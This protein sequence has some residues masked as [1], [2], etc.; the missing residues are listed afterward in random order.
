MNGVQQDGDGK[1]R[2]ESP[3]LQR[4]TSRGHGPKPALIAIDLGAESCRVSLLRWV[5]G[6]PDLQLVHRFPNGPVH[7]GNSLRWDIGRI[8]EGVRRGLELCAGLA[9]EGIAALGV[10]GWAVDYVRLAADGKPLQN[11]FCYRD[12]RNV[13]ALRSVHARIS[14]R[15]LYALT[16]AQILTLNTLYQLHADTGH[17][18]QSFP[19]QNVPE[20]VL[21]YLGGRR[22][23][24]YTNAT[25]TQLLDV[26]SQQW[27][28]EIFE[29][30]R[31]DLKAAPP[32]VKPGSV[33]GQ[34]QGPLAALPALRDTRLIAPACHDT[35]SA[36]AGIPAHGD[37]WGF[38][39]SG[40]WSLV[41]GVLDVPCVTEAAREENFSNEGGVGG[42]IYFLKNVNGMWLL[43][44]CIERW[45]EQGTAWMPEKLV[46]AC[47][48]L[49][50]P[51]KL[52][53]V[54]DPTLL[55][56]GHMPSRINAQLGHLGASPIPEEPAMAP[57]VASLIFHSLAA[58]YAAV[59][60]SL[61]RVTG[62]KLKRLFVVGG[63]AKNTFLNRLTAQAT[64]LEVLTGSTE[65]TTIGN[66]AIQLAALSGDYT[67]ETGVLGSAV[68]SWAEVLS[69]RPVKLVSAQLP[70]AIIQ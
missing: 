33:V 2:E 70:S 61:A 60:E 49:P 45:Q 17:I 41:G 62:K 56:P 66:F 30:A 25:H 28:E 64:G 59:L 29:A 11:P 18:E 7:E 15:R 5:E 68:A 21:S 24:E 52:I 23:S 42:R 1:S 32:V 22:V 8:C 37:D 19:W 36:I 27:C 20:F 54:D 44:Q 46:E 9:P 3:T 53:Q 38:I 35:A 65:S 63:G 43:Q 55:L 6:E 31:L 51:E 13:A 57:R 12:E 67:E 39:S 58:R 10:D 16:G 14:P 69:T 48:A 50:A 40:T 4:R 34:L 26:R 47:V